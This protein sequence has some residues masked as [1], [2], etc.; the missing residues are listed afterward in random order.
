MEWPVSAGLCTRRRRLGTPKRGHRLGLFGSPEVVSHSGFSFFFTRSLCCRR[1][2]IPV[3]SI[4][5][6]VLGIFFSV[7]SLLFILTW[8]PCRTSR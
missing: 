4:P 2:G 7:F 3:V 5:F 8:C 6:N 1:S